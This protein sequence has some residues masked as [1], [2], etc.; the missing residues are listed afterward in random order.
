MA[1]QEPADHDLPRAGPR[2]LGL[3]AVSVGLAATLVA[4]LWSVG[5]AMREVDALGALAALQAERLAGLAALGVTLAALALGLAWRAELRLRRSQDRQLEARRSVEQAV[6]AQKAA[7][8]ANAVKGRFLANLSH[9]LRTPLTGVVGL[10][11]LMH[12]SATDALQRDR[13]AIVERSS[14]ALLQL[15]ND[16]LDFSRLDSGPVRMV[17]Q[18]TD[19]RE[20]LDEACAVTA[21]LAQSKGLDMVLRVDAQLP[22]LWRADPLRLRQALTNLM[23]NAVKFTD[24]GHVQVEVSQSQAG[25]LAVEVADSGLGIAREDIARLFQPF[26]QLDASRTRRHGGAG[27]GL[28]ISRELIERMGGRIEVRSELGVGSTFAV[29]LPAGVGTLRHLPP[30][31]PLQRRVAR[32]WLDPGPVRDALASTLAAM[33][34]EVA[35]VEGDPPLP[36]DE[37]WT[38]ADLPRLARLA[39]AW[40]E[41]GGLVAMARWVDVDAGAVARTAGAATMLM[42]PWRHK[43]LQLL[44]QGQAPPLERLPA[45]GEADLAAPSAAGLDPAQPCVL[46]VEDDPVSATV[47]KL[48]LGRLGLGVEHVSAGLAG[49]AAAAQRRHSIVLMDCQL[50]DIDGLEASRRIRLAEDRAGHART[51][52]IALTASEALSDESVRTDAGLDGFLAKP[53]SL[54]ELAA[55]LTQHGVPMHGQRRANGGVTIGVMR[56]SLG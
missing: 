39:Q 29:Y 1:T 16:I 27:L 11:E 48:M 25:E 9:E 51:P 17:L 13:L 38:F 44:L 6:Q 10:T 14:R 43:E 31:V 53:A 18:D 46:L 12:A 50:P 35:L 33:G 56:K 21:T 15:I 42:N 55:A 24:T 45:P 7:E 28:A 5:A 26:G 23:N 40:P 54:G 30:P 41:T 8:E 19:V 32:L 4:G 52:I 49:V 34:V 36:S 2:S 22:Q 3:A 47:V 37:A 20:V